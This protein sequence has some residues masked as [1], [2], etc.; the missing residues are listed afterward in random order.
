M[1]RHG[2]PAAALFCLLMI[3]AAAFS[4]CGTAGLGEDGAEVLTIEQALAADPGQLIRVQGTIVSTGTEVI[5]ASMLLESYPPQAGGARLP[6]T[7]LDLESL[8]GLSSTAG[9]PDLAQATWS[10]YWVVLEGV[11]NDGALEVENIPRVVEAT[12]AEARVRFSPVTEPL[13]TGD[14]VWWAFDVKNLGATPLDLTFSSGQ[15]ADVIL[16]QGGTEAYRWSANKFFTEAIE[17]ITVEP[18]KALAVV[19]NDTAQVAPGEYDLTAIITAA[20]GPQSAA[21]A[22]PQ[23]KTTVTV[24]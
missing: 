20:V 11:I 1:K 21:D 2:I 19:L 18:G 15:R 7:G 24:R 8:V 3:A 10:D 4:G 12:S 9:Q 14:Q 22:L 6:V 13:V 5:L 16:S 23:L 17:T